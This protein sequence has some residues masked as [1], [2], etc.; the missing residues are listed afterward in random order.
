[1]RRF[2]KNRRPGNRAPTHDEAVRI[3]E[4]KSG[5]C[6][7]CLIWA[8]AG[9]MPAEHVATC[10]Q[11]DHAKSGNLRR[12]H[13]FGYASCLWHHQGRVPD[14]WTHAQMREHFG[15][16]KMDGSRLY[17]ATYG[18]E[19]ELIARQSELLGDVA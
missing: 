7:P 18:S 13:A 16:S 12:G 17:H 5:Q 3:V 1:M 11:Y 14:G 2:R 15:P 6:I 19:D 4:A 9:H 10:C 8:E